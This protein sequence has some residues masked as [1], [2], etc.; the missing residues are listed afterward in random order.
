MA[1]GDV[2]GTLCPN[3]KI[4]ALGKY[5]K[6][7]EYLAIEIPCYHATNEAYMRFQQGSAIDH[8]P[9]KRRYAEEQV[10]TPRA[11]SAYSIP[12]SRLRVFNVPVPS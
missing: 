1:N 5:E 2:F 10:F 3:K 7:N 9:R 6:S 11:C 8:I 4:M 12:V